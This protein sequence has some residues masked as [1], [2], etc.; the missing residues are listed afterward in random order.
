MSGRGYSQAGKRF[1]QCV[2]LQIIFNCIIGLTHGL[3]A[4]GFVI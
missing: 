2:G 4:S 1:V 3:A